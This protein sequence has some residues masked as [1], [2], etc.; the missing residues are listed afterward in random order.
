MF[1]F[2]NHLTSRS[3]GILPTPNT[4]SL[5]SLP[6]VVPPTLIHGSSTPPQ[7]SPTTTMPEIG[8]TTPTCPFVLCDDLKPHHTTSSSV[9]KLPMVDPSTIDAP[10]S[11]PPPLGL[12]HLMVTKS[13]DG[14][15]PPRT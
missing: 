8:A 13:H 1:H 6:F 2:A 15:R 4:T 3:S 7:S 12:F 9:A 5:V 10:I 14:T 11:P